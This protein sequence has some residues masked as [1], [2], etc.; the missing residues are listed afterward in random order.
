MEELQEDDEMDVDE[1]IDESGLGY[2]GLK[3]EELTG[4]TDFEAEEEEFV[5]LVEK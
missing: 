5:E 4:D 1:L 3:D 2:D